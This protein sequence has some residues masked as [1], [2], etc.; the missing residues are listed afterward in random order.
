M[1]C[2]HVCTL[3]RHCNHG[4]LAR[5]QPTKKSYL[6]PPV[7][8]PGFWTSLLFFFFSLSFLS[9]PL[10][11]RVTQNTKLNLEGKLNYPITFPLSGHLKHTTFSP[12]PSLSTKPLCFWAQLWFQLMPV[13]IIA[14]SCSSITKLW[15]L[16]SC[17]FLILKDF[18]S[19]AF[20]ICCWNCWST[21]TY[22]PL[23]SF[24]VFLKHYCFQLVVLFQT[25]ISPFSVGN[26]FG[27]CTRYQ[28]GLL[29][30]HI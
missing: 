17:P 9:W 2:Q 23:F 21:T 27:S 18:C 3:G 19:M 20:L 22:T 6:A 26:N 28:A 11:V 13:L 1:V 24:S 10:A 25:G 15:S 5:K 7:L 30:L 14:I 29:P 12:F 4:H 16:H 8:L